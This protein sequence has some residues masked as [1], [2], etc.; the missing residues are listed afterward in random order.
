MRTAFLPQ[1]SDSKAIIMQFNIIAK[2][3]TLVKRFFEYFLK[4][5]LKS[6]KTQKIFLVF[7]KKALAI[8]V[9]VC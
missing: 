6:G 5:F 1:K 8:C 3:P 9:F 2:H 7:F 4:K